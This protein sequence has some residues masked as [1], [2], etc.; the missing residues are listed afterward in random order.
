MSE[1]ILLVLRGNFVNGPLV[2]DGWWCPYCHGKI[3]SPKNK[4]DRLV[5]CGHCHYVSE[6]M[7]VPAKVEAK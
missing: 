6:I 4:Y 1:D 7:R 2:G 5:S 3:K